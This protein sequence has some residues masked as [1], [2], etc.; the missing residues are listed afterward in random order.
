VRNG[1]T[2]CLNRGL[3][4]RCA[5]FVDGECRDGADGIRR[6]MAKLVVDHGQ[7]KRV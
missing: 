2:G 7:I 3:C 6:E 1:L 4:A 5:G